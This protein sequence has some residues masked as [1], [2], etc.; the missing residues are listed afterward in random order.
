MGGNRGYLSLLERGVNSP[1][2]SMLYQLGEALHIQL[3]GAPITSQRA[4]DIGLIQRRV[5]DR[6]ALIKEADAVADEI[7]LCAPQAVRAIKSIV[8]TGRNLPVEYSWKFAEPIHTIIN[9]TEDR[10]EGPKAF[11][12]NRKPEWKNR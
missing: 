6:A 5:A 7:C 8:K 1:S 4:Y 11:A 12:E 2:L 9:S 3:T 10:L